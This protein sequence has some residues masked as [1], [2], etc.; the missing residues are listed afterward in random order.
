MGTAA[1]GR[2]EPTI[3]VRRSRPRRARPSELAALFRHATE[4][5]MVISENAPRWQAIVDGVREHGEAW[6]QEAPAHR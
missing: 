5:D 1:A 3:V 6:A 4:F 2:A